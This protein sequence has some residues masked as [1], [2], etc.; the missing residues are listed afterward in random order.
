MRFPHNVR[1]E[2]HSTAALQASETG[3]TVRRQVQFERSPF[4]KRLCALWLFTLETFAL[5]AVSVAHVPLK[6]VSSEEALATCSGTALQ[7][8]HPAVS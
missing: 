7:V 3:C 5:F 8:F 4:P 2:P 1:L 6:F